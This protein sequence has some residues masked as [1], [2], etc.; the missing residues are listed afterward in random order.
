[1]QQGD[2]FLSY[3]GLIYLLSCNRRICGYYERF[4]KVIVEVPSKGIVKASF[5]TSLQSNFSFF[6]NKFVKDLAVLE[7]F[8]MNHL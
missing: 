5:C 2:A 7:K 8:G 6:F 3:P 1:M 4:R